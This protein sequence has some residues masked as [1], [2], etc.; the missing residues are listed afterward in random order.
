[1]KSY[2]LIFS[3]FLLLSLEG[4]AQQ[5]PQG[6]KVLQAFE[7]DDVE[8]LDGPLKT[9][10][11]QVKA[12]YL[13]IPN[14]DLLKGFRK[15][16]GLP[17]NGAHNLGGWYTNDVFHVF[18]QIL[19]GLSRLYAV[20]GDVDCRNKLDALIKGW[21]ETIDTTG[22]FYYSDKQHAPHYV[23]EKIVG[24]LV[25]AHVFAGN[26]EA[27]QHLNTITNWAVKNLKKSRP[28]AFSSVGVANE[29][30]TLSEN[31][32]RAW[33]VTNDQKYYDFAHYWEY[34]E[35]WEKIAQK[36]DIF[37]GGHRYHAYS[38]L[39]TLS[40]AAAAYQVKGEEHY[41]NTLINGFDFFQEEQC[42]VTGGFGPNETLFPKDKLV[43]KF[44]ETQ[45]SFETQ[46]G[47]WAGFKLSKYLIMFT[48]NARYGDWIEKLMINGIGADIPM[49]EDGRVLYYSNYNPREGAKKNY[50][51]GWS[52]CT[53]T[54]PQAVA[55]YSNLIYFKDEQG[56]YAN[57]FVPSRVVL[58]SMEVTQ[59]TR[60]PENNETTFTF[61]LFKGEVKKTIFFRN[62]SWAT[63]PPEVLVNGQKVAA[64]EHEG[65]LAINRTWKNNDEMKLIFP[66]QLTIN[67]LDPNNQYPAAITY[68]PVAMAMRNNVMEDYPSEL[69]TGENPFHNFVPVKGEPLTYHVQG[70]PE[71]LVRPYYQYEENEP[72]VMYI[73]PAVKNRVLEKDILTTGTWLRRGYYHSNE[74]GATIS[75]TFE[76]DG[77]RLYLNCFPKAGKLRVDIDGK[78]VE[79]IDEYDPGI[80]I[81][82][83]KDFKNLGAG[84]HTV[85]I[86]VLGEK[87]PRSNN[88]FVYLTGFE[89]LK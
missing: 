71:L 81:D 62:P 22:F 76:G 38:H 21:A 82:F 19:S 43:E 45:N 25:D 40:S 6:I 56:L 85:K 65:W 87:N 3:T 16:V 70:M 66:M 42:Y 57:L 30:Y 79:T 31:L 50:F 32:Y 46:C 89:V 10:Q 64:E 29:W 5:Q 15:R 60:F 7:Y 37:E 12:Y 20:T 74:K 18:G 78:T 67:R 26:K 48:G 34:N 1:M 51:L 35:F 80:H 84:Q 47:S 9:Q 14:D 4:L 33:L 27:L 13:R 72:Y 17:T 52:C 59:Q 68:G 41:M 69:V 2:L 54:R 49:S 39:N 73:D 86:T 28:Y 88:H 63:S 53:G 77:I 83:Y 23:Y 24:G 36:K 8:L 11:D 44:K 55:E 58:D 75:T 61:K